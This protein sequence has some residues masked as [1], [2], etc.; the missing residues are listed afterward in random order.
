MDQ[1]RLDVMAASSCLMRV[2]QALSLPIGPINQ[3]SR[4]AESRRAAIG[5]RSPQATD[6]NGRYARLQQASPLLRCDACSTPRM[7]GI[8]ALA[9]VRSPH[10]C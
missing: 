8:S 3:R 4:S 6:L 9:V 5:L 7:S 1:P 10:S 2:T